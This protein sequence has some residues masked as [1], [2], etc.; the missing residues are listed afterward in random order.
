M[1]NIFKDECKPRNEQPPL[2]KKLVTAR[3]IE[4]LNFLQN[5]PWCFGRSVN[6]H[7]NLSLERITTTTGPQHNK[8]ALFSRDKMALSF[9]A[10]GQLPP[11]PTTSLKPKN[12]CPQLQTKWS[13]CRQKRWPLSSGR[14]VNCNG[15]D[16]LL[17]RF[18]QILPKPKVILL[19]KEK[20]APFF[21]A[22]G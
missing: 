3:E 18:P 13:Y 10:I 2:R 17:N 7:Q 11:S 22:I 9:E 5:R 12:N 19:L 14:S 20:M 8:V 6:C 1:P 21:G 4:A 16:R 15:T